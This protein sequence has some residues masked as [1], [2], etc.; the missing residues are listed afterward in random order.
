MAAIPRPVIHDDSS[1]ELVDRRESLAG[2][3]GFPVGI[4]AVLL[5][6]IP[7]I[8]FYIAWVPAVFAVIAGIWGL[9]AGKR[10]GT[11]LTLS[12]SSL[13]V[14]LA[15]FLITGGWLLLGWLIANVFAECYQRCS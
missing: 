5:A 15:S 7:P 1:V 12:M 11:S 13:I 4:L 8:S 10:L 3:I 2:A 14:G 9:W 6:V